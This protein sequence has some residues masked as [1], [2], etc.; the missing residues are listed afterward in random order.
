MGNGPLN[1]LENIISM[2]YMCLGH[3]EPS[4]GW[5]RNGLHEMA[6]LRVNSDLLHLES[7]FRSTDPNESSNLQCDDSHMFQ[8]CS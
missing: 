6:I 5:K 1:C 4:L 8:T 3:V 7:D 2:N